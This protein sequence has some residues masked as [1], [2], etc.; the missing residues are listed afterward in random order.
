MQPHQ[1]SESVAPIVSRIIYFAL[2]ILAV[3]AVSFVFARL[4]AK[5]R[6]VRKAVFLVASLVGFTFVFFYIFTRT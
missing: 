3:S 6:P 1:I 2:G 5:S 4:L